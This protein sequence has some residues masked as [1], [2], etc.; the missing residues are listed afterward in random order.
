[1]RSGAKRRGGGLSRR[2]REI[3]PDANPLRRG[4]DRTE[5]KIL[6]A[7][8]AVFLICAPIITF[9]AGAYV[10]RSALLAQQTSYQV[11]AVLQSNAQPLA[12]N[13]HKAAAT[14]AW[15]APDGTAQRGM[16]F[17]PLGTRARS[18][19]RIWVSRSGQLTGTPLR[20]PGLAGDVAVAALLASAAL[21]SVLLGSA[22]IVRWVLYRRR[23]AA[24]DAAWQSI[25]PQWLTGN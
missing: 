16:V 6:G 21:G 3:W 24:W 20:G 18:A 12:N 10:Y 25:E 23:L 8:C 14:A 15:K 4:S 13:G 1:M 17:V 2:L 22:A 19:V 9:L 7:L 5:A 11:V